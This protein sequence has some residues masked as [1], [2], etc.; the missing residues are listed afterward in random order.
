MD[1]LVKTS[2][3]DKQKMVDE[4]IKFVND[5]F[6]KDISMYRDCFLNDAGF[7]VSVW[8]DRSGYVKETHIE[9]KSNKYNPIR[10]VRSDI[11]PIGNSIFD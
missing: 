11:E 7:S 3:S 10:F 8:H 1:S 4:C 6:D 5:F 2:W 9:I